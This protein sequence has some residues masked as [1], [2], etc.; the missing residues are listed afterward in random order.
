MSSAEKETVEMPQPAITE[1]RS[2]PGG[3]VLR[4]EF[5]AA[6]HTGL[7]RSNNEDHY[8][9]VKRMRGREILLTNVPTAG[10]KLSG[11][12]AYVMIVADGMGGCGHGEL[13]SEII[14]RVGWELAGDAPT[15]IMK[16]D[17]ANPNEIREHM[18]AFGRQMQE[19][20][21]ASALAEPQLAGMGTTWTCAYFMGRDAVIAHV[22]DSRAY[23]FRDG[24]LQKLTRDHTFAQKL[25]DV[26]VPPAETA[27]FKHLLVNS[28]SALPADV[29]IDV[30]HF[31]VQ[32]GDRLLVCSDGLTDMVSDDEIA[33]T[34]AGATG[35]QSTCD[36]LI[37]LALQHGGRDNVTAVI[38]DVHSDEDRE[39][40]G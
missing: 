40:F 35:P 18:A 37:D 38:A 19:A 6:S 5:G 4:F 10:L 1:C 14:L 31:E 33:A 21:R 28:F 13:A 36:A 17:A 34:L 25:Q 9:V 30:D 24:T 15:W 2:R 29:K 7:L 8:A 32:P 27:R 16:Y 11:D 39:S 22:G 3:P 12:E 20:M 23:H 26:G